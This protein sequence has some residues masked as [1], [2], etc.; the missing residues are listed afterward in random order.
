MLAS[1]FISGHK[2]TNFAVARP[3]ACIGTSTVAGAASKG[4]GLRGDVDGGPFALAKQDTNL[5]KFPFEVRAFRRALTNAALIGA[6]VG[7]AFGAT[8]LI[9]GMAR[10]AAETV[11]VERLVQNAEPGT[12]RV[13]LQ[14]AVGAERLAASRRGL[15]VRASLAGADRA[16]EPLR[17]VGALQGAR[18]LDCLTQ[19]V[20]F[21]ARGETSAGQA[22]VAQVVLNRVHHPAFPKT[23]CGVVYQGAG[24]RGCQFSFACDGSMQARREGAAWVRA[25][26]VA[27]RAMSGFVMGDVGQATHFH[28]LGVSPAWG[29]RLLRTAQVGLHVFYRFGRASAPG[30]LRPDAPEG[31]AIAAPP[32][33]RL[34]SA[35]LEPVADTATFTSL[36]VAADVAK[37][38]PAAE[39]PADAKAAD[40]KTGS[41]TT[42]S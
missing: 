24:G 25:R 9:A 29:P 42:N 16:A 12:V 32:E 5:L 41:S 40:P 8:A 10:P 35:V 17:R 31:R 27:G 7:A 19:A 11:R 26:Y 2:L 30:F 36:P 18:E 1:S 13:A 33:I 4:R 38:A 15:M 23:V 21:E 39:R 20:Y 28:T 22:A 6:S 37:P 34:A 14:Q 3:I